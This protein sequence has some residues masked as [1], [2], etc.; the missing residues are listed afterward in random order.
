MKNKSSITEKEK[1]LDFALD[2]FLKNGFYKT[3]MD[4][5]A[6]E[7]RIS[8]KTIYKNFKS[9]DELVNSI[10][11]KFTT[12][13][14]T[15]IE[16]IMKDESDSLTK[17][18]HLFNTMGETALKMSDKWV[19]DVKIHM[20]KLWQKI[21][22]FRTKKAYAV[23]G[24]IIK[25]GQQEGVIIDKPAEIIIHLF[26]NAIRSI[27]NVDFLYYQKFNYNE[28]FNHTFEIIFN[29]ILTTQGKNKFN[30]IFTKVMQ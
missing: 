23:L 6:R 13:I 24:N 18:F 27:V 21:D 30:K 15:R 3:S 8:K 28:A 7:I 25:Q 26:V 12:Q 14:S 4:E 16:E 2:R 9:K 20:P 22:D 17:A 11:E 10:V 1:I 19:A 5:L 29:G